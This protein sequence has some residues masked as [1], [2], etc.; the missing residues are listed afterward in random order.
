MH[1]LHKHSSS[2]ALAKRKDFKSVIIWISKLERILKYS[3]NEANSEEKTRIERQLGVPIWS[4][5]WS[6][7]QEDGTDIL[8]IAEWNG[9]ILFYTIGGEAIRRERSM[10]FIPFKVTH[11]P[12]DQYLLVCSSGTFSSWVWSC[13]VHLTTSYVALGSQDGTITYGDRY[14]YRE[15]MTDVIIQHLI[16]NQKIRIKYKDLVCRIAV[17]QNRLAVQLLEHVI[18]YEPSGTGDG[19]HYRIRDKLNQMFNCNLLIVTSNHLV[20]CLKI[21]SFKHTLRDAKLPVQDI[22]EITG[23]SEK[24]GGR[25]KILHPVFMLEFLPD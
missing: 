20:L 15:N 3:H 11:F 5:L 17:Y 22:S 12:E 4:L 10:T 2:C 1:K 9:V 24:L 14:A 8:C 23:A 6:P 25:V 7:L 19:M 13:A 18:I 16:T 21:F